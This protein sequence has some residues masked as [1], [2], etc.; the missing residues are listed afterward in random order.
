MHNISVGEV[1]EATNHNKQEFWNHLITTVKGKDQPDQQ[2][3]GRSSER[4]PLECQ[5]SERQ[6]SKHPQ[7]TKYEGE[8]SDVKQYDG[9]EI[10]PAERQILSTQSQQ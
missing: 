4:Q 7:V 8:W 3:Q 2:V 10:E 9:L 5:P 6:P 1:Q